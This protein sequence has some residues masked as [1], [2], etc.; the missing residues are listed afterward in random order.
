MVKNAT[1][2]VKGTEIIIFKGDTEDF[3]TLTEIARFK[4]AATMDAIIQ[5]WLCNCNTI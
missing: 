4:D 2:E 5:S 3:T 1:I